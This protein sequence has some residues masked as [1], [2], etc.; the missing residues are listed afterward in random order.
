MTTR[1]LKRK[2]AV[3]FIARKIATEAVPVN[4]IFRALAKQGAS[5]QLSRRWRREEKVP[6]FQVLII[7]DMQMGTWK[8]LCNL[9]FSLSSTDLWRRGPGRGGIPL[10]LSPVGAGRWDTKL[11]L[12]LMQILAKI[13]MHS[14][15]QRRPNPNCNRHS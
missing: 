10:S 1:A 13:E 2:W 14:A 5:Q 4:L 3:N 12:E 6:K 15:N 7:K 11:R 8:F 9:D